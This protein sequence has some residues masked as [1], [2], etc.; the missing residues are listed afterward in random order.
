MYTLATCSAPPWGPTILSFPEAIGLITRYHPNETPHGTST[1]PP[2]PRTEPAGWSG[3]L[4]PWKQG[5]HSRI[6]VC[7]P[8]RHHPR[9]REVGSWS[10]GKC[11]CRSYSGSKRP[12]SSLCVEAPP[13]K[14]GSSEGKALAPCLKQTTLR[15]CP[16]SGA[17]RG[18]A[19]T[20]V[21]SAFRAQLI[22]FPSLLLHSPVW[23][24]LRL[25]PSETSCTRARTHTHTHTRPVT[26]L[27]F[28]FVE[29]GKLSKFGNESQSQIEG[30]RRGQ[31]RMRWLSIT[32]SVDMNLSKL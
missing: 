32:D 21:T 13:P 4:G 27:T 12:I 31:Q 2:G 26:H 18:L 5:S 14:A 7:G 28:L 29:G 1:F 22:P 24:S 23:V 25:V 19:E 16:S 15:D 6:S 8:R 10:S 9:C 30:K 20:F 17:R 11:F 3:D